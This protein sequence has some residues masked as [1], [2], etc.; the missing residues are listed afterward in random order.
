MSGLDRYD[1]YSFKI[2]RRRLDDSTSLNDNYIYSLY[3]LPGKKMWVGTGNVVSIYDSHT[4]KF[5]AT[6]GKKIGK[7]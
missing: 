7:K 2:F 4:E 3:E 5:D 1:G 6:T